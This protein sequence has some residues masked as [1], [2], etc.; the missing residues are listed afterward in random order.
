MGLGDRH[1]NRTHQQMGMGE[2]PIYI[3]HEIEMSRTHQKIDMHSVVPM[4]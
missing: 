4:R 2:G 1:G 3:H